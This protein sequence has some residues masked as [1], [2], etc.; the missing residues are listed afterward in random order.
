M[1]LFTGPPLVPGE[2]AAALLV[3]ADGRYLMQ[4]R[5]ALDFIFFPDWWGC[6]GGG[7]EPGETPEQAMRRELSEELAFAPVRM[8]PFTTVGLDFSFAGRGALPR[9]FFEIPIT[10]RDV[11][12]MVLG[13]GQAMELIPG[14]D[15]MSRPKMIPYDA[16][17]IWQHMCRHRL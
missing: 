4:Q 11:D 1:D 12:T 10:E 3:T 17:A 7:L 16:V 6:F 5:D 8:T 13:E 2:A 9:H 15:I 14:K